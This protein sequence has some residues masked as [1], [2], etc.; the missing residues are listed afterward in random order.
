[1]SSQIYICT[2]HV[3]SRIKGHNAAA[4]PPSAARHPVPRIPSQIIDKATHIIG[5]KEAHKVINALATKVGLLPTLLKHLHDDNLR[6]RSDLDP[7]HCR[8]ITILKLL[9][10]SQMNHA[11]AIGALKRPLRKEQAAC[12][13]LDQRWAGIEYIPRDGTLH[14]FFQTPCLRSYEIMQN[15]SPVSELIIL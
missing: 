2:Q 1:M 12:R 13:D 10:L 7:L 3:K 15:Q 4:V 9:Q 8:F 5:G 6:H 14:I 11:A